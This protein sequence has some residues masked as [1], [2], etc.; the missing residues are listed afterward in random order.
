MLINLL[1]TSNYVSYNIKLAELLGLHS[2]IYISE[3]MNINDKAIRKNKLDDNYFKLQREYIKSRTTLDEKEQLIIEDN[4]IKLGILERGA[5]DT[6]L[7]LNITTLTT[8]MMSA[9]EQLIDNIKK[10]N[11]LKNK[12]NRKTK[13]EQIKINLK[14][15]LIIDN[16][17]LREAYERWIDAVYEKDGWMTKEAITY[18]QEVIDNASNRDLDVA[19]EILKIASVNAYR[20]MTWA[21][22]AYKSQYKVNY[23]IKPTTTI[24]PTIT[25]KN[26]LSSEVF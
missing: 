9:D 22:N 18:A 23:K 4:L 5:T 17:E 25:D 24:K 13:K 8:I 20:D 10:L 2:A 26:Q 12:S 3:L 15:N 21:V 11:V 19:L 6:D 16:I 14:N 1:S 7:S